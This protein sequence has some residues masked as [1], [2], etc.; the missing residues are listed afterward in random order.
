MLTRA[1]QDQMCIHD[2]TLV[3]KIWTLLEIIVYVIGCS[4][5]E[6]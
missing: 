1:Y 2:K 4:Q 5:A 6:L 3:H